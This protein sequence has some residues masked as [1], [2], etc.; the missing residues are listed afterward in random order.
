MYLA[1]VEKGDVKVK[2]IYTAPGHETSKALRHGSHSVTCNYTDAC[3]YLVS[4]H[5]LAPPQIEV[6]QTSN[7]SLLLIY[8][9]QKDEKLSRPGQVG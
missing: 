3:L 8:L 7:C 9:P 4:V 2:W 6:L 1:A 5:Q